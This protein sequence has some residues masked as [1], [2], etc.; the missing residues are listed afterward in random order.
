M[1]VDITA[2][3][4]PAFAGFLMAYDDTFD[5]AHPLRGCTSTSTEGTGGGTSELTSVT[6]APGATVTIVAAGTNPD[7]MTSSYDLTIIA[8]PIP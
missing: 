7:E 2:T 5:A 3:W 4:Q 8:A 1:T 6:V